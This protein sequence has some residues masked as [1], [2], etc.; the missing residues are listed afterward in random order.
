MKE[1]IVSSI[2]QQIK[3]YEE[4][5]TDVEEHMRLITDEYVQTIVQINNQISE[6]GQYLGK[7]T[8]RGTIWPYVKRPNKNYSRLLYLEYR[9]YA[10]RTP[11]RKLIISKRYS[12]KKQRRVNATAIENYYP[13]H[14]LEKMTKDRDWEFELL[15][16]FESKA[17]SLRGYYAALFMNY[18]NL[19]TL[20]KD[21]TKETQTEK[22]DAHV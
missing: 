8:T 4:L 7:E 16:E 14:M 9:S 22:E 6:T 12:G 20:H 13:E 5:L 10:K 19:M 17:T 11:G 3:E 2:A 15:K 18:R 1:E 21:L